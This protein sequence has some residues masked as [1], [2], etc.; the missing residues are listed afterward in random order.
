[1]GMECGSC[2]MSWHFAPDDVTSLLAACLQ[3][4]LSTPLVVRTLSK[5]VSKEGLGCIGNSIPDT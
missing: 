3:G 5:D 1:M 2:C 4:E